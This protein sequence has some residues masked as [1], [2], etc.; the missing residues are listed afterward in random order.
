[1]IGF[2]LGVRAA[3]LPT[4]RTKR[5]R[6][7]GRLLGSRGERD[8][9]LRSPLAAA[10]GG[11][12]LGAHEVGGNI[13]A[14]QHLASDPLTFAADPW[15]VAVSL[16]TFADDAQQDM[17]GTDGVVFE[18]LGFFLRQNDHSPR[19]FCKLLKH[20]SAPRRRLEGGLQ[21]LNGATPTEAPG[22]GDQLVRKGIGQIPGVVRF[23]KRE[24]LVPSPA[25]RYPAHS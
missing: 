23:L 9:L 19:P 8:F 17:L 13:Q 3:K 7:A 11:F 5:R 12:D 2:L 1:M 20:R 18:A 10:D 4:S 16:L 22:Y 25:T 21:R 6:S 14:L 24:E 15:H